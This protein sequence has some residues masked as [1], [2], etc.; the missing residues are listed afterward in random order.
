MSLRGWTCVVVGLLAS[1]ACAGGR[2]PEPGPLVD[3]E[4]GTVL[5]Q[6]RAR[7]QERLAEGRAAFGVALPSET[8]EPASEPLLLAFDGARALAAAWH[9]RTEWLGWD[10]VAELRPV[11]R[12]ETWERGDGDWHWAG[13][14]GPP[15]PDAS[16]SSAGVPAWSERAAAGCR[17]LDRS[18]AMWSAIERE[19]YEGARSF[20]APGGF[21]QS[22]IELL[23]VDEPALC[24]SLRRLPRLVE[25]EGDTA[26]LLVG[27]MWRTH[28]GAAFET[29]VPGSDRP[30][31][32][33]ETWRQVGG[34]WQCQ[35]MV[36]ASEFLEQRPEL[37]ARVAR[38]TEEDDE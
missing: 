9:W 14:T 1:A 26:R 31:D 25:I 15:E 7:W 34:A 28:F 37:V 10:Q 11:A 6:V 33:V 23:L 27:L 8:M 16:V 35:D 21:L 4:R 18:R 5:E 38:L 2:R 36:D 3:A 24:Y 32:V 30:L 12:V 13:E 19:D 20:V 22:T 29:G 17:V